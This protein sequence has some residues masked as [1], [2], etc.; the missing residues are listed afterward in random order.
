MAPCTSPRSFFASVERLCT[1]IR[2]AGA[3]P[4][5]YATWAYQK[6]GAKLAAKGWDYE[7]M[8]RT[9]SEAYRQAARENH[10]LLAE[11]GRA[12]L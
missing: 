4:V 7:T 5:L 1:Q 8:A 12:V 9:L 6:G 3:V 2:A 11:V 10:A